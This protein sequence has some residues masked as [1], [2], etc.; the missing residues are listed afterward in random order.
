MSKLSIII[1]VYFN[2]E[3][4]KD[5]YEDLKTKVLTK[6]DDYEIV[7]VDDGSKDNSW[8]IMQ[9]IK[10]WDSKIKLVKLS[11]N[12]GSHSAILAGMSVCTGD[13]AVVKAADLQE[14]S[15]LLL[16]MYN[17]WREGNKVVLAVR[18]DRN[19]SFSTKLF[20]NLYYSIVRKLV[21]KEMPKTGFDCY[22][23]DGKVIDVLLNLDENNSA[24]TLQILW[25]G[26][27]KSIVYYTRLKREK[28]KSRWTLSKKIK[29]IV[30]SIISF[31]YV[32]IRISTVIGALAFIVSIIWGFVVFF[33]KLFG[34]IPIQGFSTLMIFM[35][36]SSGITLFMLGI[37]GEYVWRATD[38]ARN[39]P[40]YIIDECDD[41]TKDVK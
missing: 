18:E 5:L 12:F 24:L 35:L 23:V 38:A 4:L 25:V 28:G 2:E 31:S 14:P 16:D 13:C 7:M 10:E 33:M 6:L 11:R 8:K 1:P 26:F 37:I 19:E 29:L 9:E 41:E 3:S 30:D 21:S 22:L 40:N 34:N 27:K 15:E 20:A 36:F 39:R 32:P 17:S